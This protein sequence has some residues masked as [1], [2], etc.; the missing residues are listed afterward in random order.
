ML[1]GLYWLCTVTPKRKSGSTAQETIDWVVLEEPEMGLHPKGIQA[2]LLLVLELLRR[3]Y[4]VVLSTHS[5]VVLEM[6]WAI[7]ELKKRQSTEASVRKLFDL[8]A[9]PYAKDLASA[10]LEKDYRVYFFDR[11]SQARDISQLDPGAER[12]EE[13][14]WGGLVG[15]ASKANTAVADAVNSAET[16]SRGSPS[17]P[18]G[19]PR[20]RQPKKAKHTAEEQ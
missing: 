7:Q 10:A 9:V 16:G 12:A 19:K 3:G 2:V 14:E 6:T 1:M 8:S 20:T 5:P 4:R 13:S 15:F 11:N 17:K 18:R